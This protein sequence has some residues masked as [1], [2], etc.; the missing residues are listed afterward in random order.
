MLLR[1]KEL[2]GEIGISQ[3]KLADA[4]EVSQQSINK[5][6]NHDIEPDIA[7]LKKIA[8]FFDVSID[9]IVE[10]SNVKERIVSRKESDLNGDEN[11]VIDDFRKLPETDKTIIRLM[12]RSLCEK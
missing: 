9:Y 3:Q 6:E 11:R 1:L 2:R 7:T 10:L 8:L 12:L 4:I 5:Y